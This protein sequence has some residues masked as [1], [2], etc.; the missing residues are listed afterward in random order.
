MGAT[1]GRVYAVVFCKEQKWHLI[2]E[3]FCFIVFSSQYI[4]SFVL[5][6]ISEE[7]WPP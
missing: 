7:L 6:K 4:H 2:Q 1:H 5:S 3:L